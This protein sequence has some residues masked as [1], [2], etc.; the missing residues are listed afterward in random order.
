MPKKRK[1][2]IAIELEVFDDV[3]AMAQDLGISEDRCGW[4]LMKLWR[5]CWQQ[6]TAV[7]N[8]LVIEG[9]L[10]GGVKVL[11]A[12]GYLEIL[13]GSEIR[14]RGLDRYLRIK[15]AQSDAA[16]RTNGAVSG[17]LSVPADLESTENGTQ[18]G[19]VSGPLTGTPSVGK[20][21]DRRSKIIKEDLSRDREPELAL[22]LPKP[23]KPP[24]KTRQPSAWET[25]FFDM[26]AARSAR[27]SELGMDDA[28]EVLN[29]GMVNT[30]LARVDEEIRKLAGD[31]YL[32][33]EGDILPVW[34]AYLEANDWAR[35][36]SPPYPLQAF[37]SPGQLK[38]AREHY[39]LQ[40]EAQLR[41]Q[42]AK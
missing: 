37:A 13:R 26:Q 32:S 24:K 16:K 31:A 28:H 35:T 38:K 19:T 15:A 18:T 10:P 23:E 40:V 30:L 5:R 36:L 25:L 21:E 29:P 39:E 41:A 6:R 2:F 42:E 11:N 34:E 3:P 20:I 4:Q 1:P 7:V 14:I 12:F 22:N 27:L 17:P 8:E 9:F 33:P